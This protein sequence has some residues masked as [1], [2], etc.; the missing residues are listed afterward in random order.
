MFDH[1]CKVSPILTNRCIR[2]PL[3]LSWAWRVQW[4][5]DKPL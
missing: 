3:G 4:C 2:D 1:Y 5:F